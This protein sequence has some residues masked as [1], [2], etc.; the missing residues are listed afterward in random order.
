MAQGTV[1]WFNEEKGYGFISR[2]ATGAVALARVGRLAAVRSA[3]D[4]DGELAEDR[5]EPAS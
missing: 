5:L 1:K 4:C 3:S 2:T